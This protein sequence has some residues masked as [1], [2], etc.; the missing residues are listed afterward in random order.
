MD[1]APT[2]TDTLLA[3]IATGLSYGEAGRQMGLNRNQV[4]GLIYRARNRGRKAKEPTLRR[5]RDNC[6]TESR[7][8]ESWAEWS[9]RRKAERAREA[10]AA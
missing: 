3:L 6:W 8:T 4:A 5:P 1:P 7:L 2:R 9:A 10:Q